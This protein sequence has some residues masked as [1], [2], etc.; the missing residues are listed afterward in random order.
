MAPD[1]HIN[2]VDSQVWSCQDAPNF[3]YISV[4]ACVSNCSPLASGVPGAALARC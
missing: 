2:T 4:L 1:A 3:L